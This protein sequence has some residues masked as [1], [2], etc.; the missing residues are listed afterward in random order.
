[1]SIS[2][3][4]K[5]WAKNDLIHM[6]NSISI[7][8]R[9]D[10][11][12]LNRVIPI[13]NATKGSSTVEVLFLN[14]S[15]RISR[16][17]YN[18]DSFVDDK[19]AEQAYDKISNLPIGTVG[20]FSVDG[21]VYYLIEIEHDSMATFDRVAYISRG[22]PLDDLVTN[23]NLVLFSIT[24][25]VIVTAILITSKVTRSI[26]KPIE[27]I[28]HSIEN[29]KS[30]DV[31][32]INEKSDSVELRKLINEFNAMSKRIY[33]FQQSQKTFLSNASHELRTPLMSIQGYADGI[34]MGVFNDYKSTA[35][36]ISDQSKRLT[37]LVDNLL[38][39]A[40][41]ENFNANKNLEKLNL[42][43]C[44]YEILNRYKG[45]ALT[46]HIELKIDIDANIFARANDELLTGSAGNIIS[47]AIRYAKTAVSISLKEKYDIAVITIADDGIGISNIDNM[48]QRFSKGEGG[49]FG[50]GLSIAKASVDAMNGKIKVYNRGGAV[51]EIE[52]F[53]A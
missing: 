33:K 20:S 28:T 44:L 15:R 22:L 14:Q 32:E 6:A 41:A 38:I 13:I 51:F 26:A 1:M 40:R 3:F 17:A 9:G 30:D 34:E 16:F 45:Y 35:H 5:E 29:M 49:K 8:L 7:S 12:N 10:E 39:L 46:N 42:S 53:L 27:Y 24:L 47:N 19:I 50:L 11:K 48:F 2:F 36:L 31:L 18:A 52:L 4:S 37:K 21:D 43:N 23:I 25:I